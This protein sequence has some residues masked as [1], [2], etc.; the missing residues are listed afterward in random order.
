MHVPNPL[1]G[2]P[3][4]LRDV[5]KT[6][7]PRRG[8]LLIDYAKADIYY[9][10]KETGKKT[11]LADIIYQ[12]LINA[13]LEN[14]RIRITHTD[15]D[16]TATEPITPEVKDRE[17]ITWYMSIYRRVPIVEKDKEAASEE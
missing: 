1:G 12:K 8:E 3:L 5:N 9:I 4:V 2:L 16:S 7:N 6:S 11:R 13:K 14:S 15:V 17:Q 10:N